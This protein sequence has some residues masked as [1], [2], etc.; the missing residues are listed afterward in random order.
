[1]SIL[2]KNIRIIDSITDRITHH[3]IIHHNSF[4]EINEVDYPRQSYETIDGNGL[5]LMPSF[6]DM[7]CHLRDPG[8]TYKEDLES[9]QQAALSGGFTT[10]CCMAN[11]MPVCDNTNTIQYIK[12]KAKSLDMCEVIP[13]S[14]VTKGLKTKQM[15]HFEEMIDHTRLFSN[16]GEP[17]TYEKTM[18]E[19]L[20]A[21]SK[22]HFTVLTHCEPEVEMIE[23]DLKLLELYGG[24]L[25]ICHVSQ[26]ESVQLIRNAKK[27]GLKFTCEVTPHHLYSYGLDYTVHP[28]FREKK[29][30]E[31]LLQG[32]LDGTIDVIAT[33]HAPH[34]QKDKSKG[35]RGL[36]GFEHAF[37]LVYTVFKENNIPIKLLS[38]WMSDIPAKLLS[39]PRVSF[40]Q[41][42]STNFVL[43]NL[44]KKYEIK[45]SEIH[46]K[47][48]NTPF[49]SQ[50]VYG[51]IIMTIKDGKIKYDQRK[52]TPFR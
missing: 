20:K 43:V 48:K 13:I 41:K 46:S 24:N 42:S 51:Q 21:S 11:T 15:V 8:Y 22:Y 23:R 36:I 35:A 18:I 44:E 7:H 28:P 1:M 39:I 33:D 9:G 34:S 12:N 30:K 2:F 4:E 31:A 47:S 10:I 52:M 19:S 5:V 29:D 37:S 17:I 16:D 45:E 50:T 14:A 26:K 32:L 3:I 27:K 25:H 38:Q 6:I 40:K 49:L